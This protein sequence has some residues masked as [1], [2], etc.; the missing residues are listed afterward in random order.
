MK[1]KIF[2]CK[3]M[4]YQLDNYLVKF[5]RSLN[6]MCFC[7]LIYYFIPHGLYIAPDVF[8]ENW[9]WKHQTCL[10]TK[11]KSDTICNHGLVIC[12]QGSVKRLTGH[13]SRKTE[14]PWYQ[15]RKDPGISRYQYVSVQKNP[16]ISTERPWYQEAQ[17]MLLAQF[18]RNMQSALQYFCM[19]IN[20]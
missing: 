13:I 1:T 8:M 7:F 6:Q 5:F 18:S 4:C 16:G 11:E 12:N 9:R 14:R 15:Y 19:N 2:P 17:H 10:Y 3:T 20:F